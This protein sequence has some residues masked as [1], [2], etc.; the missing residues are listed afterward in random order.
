MEH[1]DKM[2]FEGILTLIVELLHKQVK[3]ASEWETHFQNALYLC[4]QEDRKVEV[5]KKREIPILDR[6]PEGFVTAKEFRA[7]TG[8]SR[9]TLQEAF[10]FIPNGHICKFQETMFFNPCIMF[11]AIKL[12]FPKMKKTLSHYSSWEHAAGLLHQRSE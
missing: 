9:N 10:K 11:E 1:R 5:P 3:D 12:N 7:V 2:A 4:Q 8:L 6:P